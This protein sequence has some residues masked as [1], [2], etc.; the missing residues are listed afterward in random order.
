[1]SRRLSAVGATCGALALT[2][3]GAIPSASAAEAPEGWH[4]TAMKAR[5]MWKTSTGD[6]VTVA[7]IDSG[8]NPQTPSLKG[9]VIEDGISG[10]AGYKATV[11][12]DGHGTSMAE[13]IAGTG[14][15]GGIK[16]LAPGAKILPIRLGIDLSKSEKKKA[17]TVAQAIRAAAD[18]DARIIN[19]SFGAPWIRD[20]DVAA[21]RYAYS[22]GKL[23]FA[24]VGNDAGKKS[25]EGKNIGYPAGYPYVVGVAAVDKA[26]TVGKFSEQGADVDLAAPGLDLSGWCDD[27]FTRYCPA[28]GTSY[29]AAIASAS[30]ALIWSVHPEW[31]NN[32]VLN[33]LIETAGRDWPREETSV[34]L[35]HGLVRP[36]IVLADPKFDPGAPDV[37]PLLKQHEVM[38]KSLEVFQPIPS[39]TP[40]TPADASS[41][42]PAGGAEPVPGG[43]GEEAGATDTDTAAAQDGDSG[44]LWPIAGAAAAVVVLGGVVAFVVMRKRRTA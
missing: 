40:T 36:R 16:G 4:L 11:D 2:M 25:P 13:N 3:V 29:A 32:Q 42:T 9:Q 27:T 34:Y 12:T 24:S 23:L 33:A 35:G 37:D 18:S 28:Q 22:K 6:G 38:F 7:V 20:E 17:P 39:P 10:T 5:E 30:A 19:M 8:V 1:M 15:G 26:S 31:T 43:K 44:A 21:V 14:A 41:K